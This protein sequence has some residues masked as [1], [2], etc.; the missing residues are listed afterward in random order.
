MQFL[1]K[2]A[3]QLKIKK[4]APRGPDRASMLDRKKEIQ[5]KFKVQLGL[6]VDKPREEGSGT[7]NTGNV[8]QKF[9]QNAEKVANKTGVNQILI[10]RCGTV[11]QLMACGRNVDSE[12]F[13]L[14]CEPTARLCVKLYPW[15]YLPVSVHK[16]LVHGSDIIK[17][18]LVPIGQLAEKAQEVKN[19]EWKRLFSLHEQ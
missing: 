7:S 12:A 10:Q 9:F 13:G 5:R 4:W 15:Y 19:K 14:N 18:F 1:L 3:Y 17:H 2:I 6:H 16:V 8:A 11:L